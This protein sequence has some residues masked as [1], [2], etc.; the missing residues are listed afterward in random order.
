MSSSL[1][2][3]LDKAHQQLSELDYALHQL[4]STDPSSPKGGDL[5]SIS[6][7]FA[8]VSVN[9]RECTDL[10]RREPNLDRRE[11]YQDRIKEMQKQ[12]DALKSQLDVLK[13]KQHETHKRQLLGDTQKNFDMYY[14]TSTAY[15]QEEHSTLHSI[16]R[17][18]D[19]LVSTGTR[20]MSSL[21]EQ[22][23][24]LIRANESALGGVK[25]LEAGRR[26]MRRIFKKLA[27]EKWI[28]WGGLVLIV[29][30]LVYFAFY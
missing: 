28:F 30:V 13:A 25:G 10:A 20:V 23:N 6:A 27:R 5:P 12:Y 11:Q 2:V 3:L 14:G 22:K 1:N 24:R 26:L 19:E 18:M 16:N 29:V 8:V 15:L 21:R 9:L 17:R 4:D 7:T